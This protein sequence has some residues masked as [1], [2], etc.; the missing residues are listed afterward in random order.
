MKSEASF[1]FTQISKINRLPV[2]LIRKREKPQFTN[3]RNIRG[4]LTI[5]HIDIKRERKYYE[6]ANKFDN[7][8]QIDKSLKDRNYQ[9]QLKKK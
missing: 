5:F 8:D 3:I 9:N 1:F 6:W 2:R 7:V 4:A